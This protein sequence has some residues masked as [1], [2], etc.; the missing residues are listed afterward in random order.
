[1][2]LYHLVLELVVVFQ[3]VC[4]VFEVVVGILVELVERRPC[5]LVVELLILVLF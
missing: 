3:L 1:L 4:M 2:G 5:R